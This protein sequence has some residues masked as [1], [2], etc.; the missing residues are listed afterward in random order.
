MLTRF[1]RLKVLVPS[2]VVGALIGLMVGMSYGGFVVIVTGLAGLVMCLVTYSSAG[3]GRETGLR[4][5]VQWRNDVVSKTLT[6]IA[7]LSLFG[8]A[9]ELG[10]WRWAPA[11][12]HFWSL[13]FWVALGLLV[14]LM[15]SQAW[16]TMVV[17]IYLTIRYRTPLRLG[18]FLEDARERHLLRSIGPVYQFRHATLQDRLAPPPDQSGV[19][20]VTS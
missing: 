20:P 11:N 14:G 15:V 6:C 9:D 10:R 8:A 3:M 7:G 19:G 17:Q 13:L 18:R 1:M 12:E 2:V 4:P 5:V 16:M